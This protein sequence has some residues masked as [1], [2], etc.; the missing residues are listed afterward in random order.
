MLMEKR[1]P[2]VFPA[3]KKDGSK[4]Y[5]ASVTHKRK[6]ISLGSY[7]TPYKAFAAY[8]EGCDLLKNTGL[9]ILD[10]SNHRV[11][12]FEKWVTLINYRDNGMY[13]TTPIYLHKKYFEYYLS[14][15]EILKFDIDDLFYEYE[16]NRGLILDFDVIDKIIENSTFDELKRIRVFDKDG[17][18]KNNLS[19]PSLEDYLKIC[20]FTNKTAVLELKNKMKESHI[21]D[22]LDIIKKYNYL[23][24]MIFISFE[25]DNLKVLRK[26]NKTIK[27]QYLNGIE[28]IN[29]KIE[30]IK[31]AKELKIDVDV[32]YNNVTKD[33]IDE[34]HKN[35]IEVNVWTVDSKEKADELISMGVDYVT[36]NILE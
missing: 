1:L 9:T 17:S 12:P 13:I 21:K 6:H 2:G 22:I 35:N 18:Y 3:Q 27:I 34:C 28:N 7:D 32:H 23:N 20:M 14:P 10:H 31:Y 16:K 19:L 36:S 4:Y 26:L 33:F 5:R 25:I 15:T 29:K 8:L 30:T 11:L 24:K